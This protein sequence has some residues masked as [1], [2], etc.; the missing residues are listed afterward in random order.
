M[1]KINDNNGYLKSNLHNYTSKKIINSNHITTTNLA[2]PI[3]ANGKVLHPN[4]GDYIF[5][6]NQVVERPLYQAGGNSYDKEPLY[7]VPLKNTFYKEDTVNH[8]NN[9]TLDDYESRLKYYNRNKK[10]SERI[11]NNLPFIRHNETFYPNPNL[12]GVKPGI[13]YIDTSFKN[14]SIVPVFK[15]NINPFLLS[16]TFKGDVFHFY[17]KKNT[18]GNQKI[19]N[20]VSPV[21][22]KP[23][24]PNLIDFDNT[25]STLP[26]NGDEPPVDNGQVLYYKPGQTPQTT[27]LGGQNANDYIMGKYQQGGLKNTSNKTNNMTK[28]NLRP[29]SLVFQSGGLKKNPGKVNKGSHWAPSPSINTNRLVPD[30]DDMGNNPIDNYSNSLDYKGRRLTTYQMYTTLPNNQMIPLS[31][32]WN[33]EYDPSMVGPRT[34]SYYNQMKGIKFQ[35]GGINPTD[36]STYPTRRMEEPTFFHQEIK[37]Q[38]MEKPKKPLQDPRNQ[39]DFYDQD[40]INYITNLQQP[41]GTHSNT[42]PLSPMMQYARVPHMQD[43]GMA[44]QELQSQQSEQMEPQS[45]ETQQGESQEMMQQIAQMLQQGGDPQQVVQQLV[46]SGVPQQQA[47]QMVQAVMQQMQGQ[48]QQQPAMKLGGMRPI[49][50]KY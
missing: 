4:T 45:Q 1:A 8:I 10:E 39:K 30:N 40:Y 20:Y 18:L 3:V 35:N 34:E 38:A 29:T 21:I 36:P 33:T 49:N 32:Y 19:T 43:G 46:Q 15:K 11:T 7:S 47:V 31:E 5:P 42:R 23:I 9:K 44:P 26:L 17:D 28:I 6:T 48:Q 13:N 14:N 27:P 25:P 12:P 22:D 50:L 24:Y 41:L 2:F 16:N 37:R